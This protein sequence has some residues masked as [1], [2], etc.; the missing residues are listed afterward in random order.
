MA[1][2]VAEA[3]RI[4][5]ELPPLASGEEGRQLGNRMAIGRERRDSNPRPP[6]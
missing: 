5:E 1:M 3:D 2:S 6:A 4:L